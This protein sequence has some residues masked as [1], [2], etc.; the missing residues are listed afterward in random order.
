MRINL[1]KFRQVLRWK[2]PASLSLMLFFS[3]CVEFEG[4]TLTYRYDRENDRLLCFQV[5]EN[6]YGGS[7]DDMDKARDKFPSV[8]TQERNQ[9]ES[10]M[11]GQ[12]TFFFDNWLLE[13]NRKDYLEQKEKAEKDLPSADLNK[14]AE[15]E[16]F[17]RLMDNI[18]ASVEVK[19]GGF[20]L[21]GGNQL[22]GY[23]YVAISNASEIVSGINEALTKHLQSKDLKKHDDFDEATWA[24]VQEAIDAGE[25]VQ[26]KG[27]QFRIRWVSEEDD[28]QECSE[29]NLLCSVKDGLDLQYEKPFGVIIVGQEND[30]V[31]ELKVPPSSK[32]RQNLIEYVA[33]TYGIKENAPID[34][35]RE[36]FLR[37]GK[38]PE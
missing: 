29:D 19:N 1:K 32:V 34:R 17:I 36:E 25:W 6:I 28:S 20:Y 16:S 30:I 27:N 33:H 15:L 21:N 22:C 7:A 26:M 5:Y 14:R 13:Y 31:T 12:R 37:T 23:Q 18:A 3:G 8:G 9:L 38:I 2:I 10:V 11:R 24:K 4:Q 35:L